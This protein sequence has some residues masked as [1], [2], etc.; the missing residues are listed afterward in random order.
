MPY[1]LIK[2]LVPRLEIVIL[3]IAFVGSVLGK[4]LALWSYNTHNLIAVLWKV[5]FPDVFFFV[6]V[7]CFIS[8]LY[9]LKPSVF[10]VRLVIV[11]SV[12]VLI[13]SLLNII[14]ISLTGIQFLPGI[15][16]AFTSNFKHLW[17]LVYSNLAV[18]IKAIIVMVL[19]GFFGLGLLVWQLLRPEPIKQSRRYH[20]RRT[21]SAGAV[22]VVLALLWPTTNFAG[23]SSFT[24][25]AL[26][27][28]SHWNSIVSLV[29]GFGFSDD[30]I[31]RSSNI[32]FAGEREVGLPERSEGSLPN[33]IL[34]FLESVS[35]SETSL[36]NPESQQTPCLSRLAKEGIA[37]HNTLV[38]MPYTNK[39]F[40]TALSSTT[41]ADEINPVEAVVS[42]KTYEGLPS[43]LSRA[44]YRTA[45]FQMSKGV[46]ECMPGIFHN[47]GFDWAWFREN[48]Q[49][50][51]SYLG[52]MNGDDIRM[53]K[54]AFEWAKQKPGPFFLTMITSVTH[55]PYAVP[56]W[57]EKPC[58]TQHERYQQAVRF[59]DYYL[60]RLCQELEGSGFKDNTIL[61]VIGDHGTSFRASKD[62]GRWIPY[63]EVIKVPW[64]IRWPGHIEAG[65]NERRLCSQLDVAPTI[66]KLL[67]FDISKAGFEGEDAL[68]PRSADRRLFFSSVAPESPAG[69]T[70]GERKV[71]YWP[72]LGKVFE[73]DLKT[74]PNENNAMVVDSIEAEQIKKDIVSWRDRTQMGI[75]PKQCANQFVFSHWQIFSAGQKAWAYYV[76]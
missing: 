15:I 48:L 46:F 50:K 66:L 2:S 32:K 19:V 11:I 8:F 73:Y 12:V 62:R 58:E 75:G 68:M 33:V 40:W 51:S 4:F 20:L 9:L 61:C 22:L 69:F 74:D 42:Q 76:P 49:D 36:A 5:A 13:W 70:E 27:F 47:F 18:H 7:F 24:V 52:Y 43:I 39:A 6:A 29:N 54:P 25:E 26:S 14:S 3:A 23:S 71:V 38:P 65:Q 60:E 44:G 30:S 37:F 64:I 67:G 56:G 72:I 34:V 21:V 59:T 35:Y 53:L 16:G 1:K 10:V 57:F 45:F 41:P 28:S 31:S 17:P 55:D 63:D